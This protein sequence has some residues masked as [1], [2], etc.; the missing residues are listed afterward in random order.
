[1]APWKAPG[2]DDLPVGF[3]KACGK[4]LAKVL[5]ILAT[6]CFK[7]GLFPREL[8]HAK[9]TVLQ[10][11]GKKPAVYK[12]AGGYR[13]IA[14]LPCLGKIIEAIAAARIASAAEEHGLLPEEQMGNRKH[15]STD[16]AIRLLVTQMQEAFR[17]KASG[18]LLQLDIKGYFDHIIHDWLIYTL[19][20]I[21]LPAWIIALI[22]AWL[23]GRRSTLFFDGAYSEPI[24][25]RAGVPQG[26]PLSPILAILFLAPLYETLKDKHPHLSIL[27]FADDT[28]ILALGLSEASTCHQLEEAW[29]TCRHWAQSRGLTFAPEKSELIH[30]TRTRKPWQQGLQLGATRITPQ[31]D[32]RFLGVWLDRKLRWGAHL[33]E[34]RKRLG[35]QRLALT[36]LAA[37]TWGPGLVRSREL[38]TKVV[39]STMAYGASAYHQ[40]TPI[41][42][43]PRGLAI[44]L[45]KEQNNCLLVVTGAY[46][47][48][49]T[50]NLEMEALVPP[51]DLYLN[52]RLAEFEARL[53]QSGLQRPIDDA[54]LKVLRRFG[55]KGRQ[56]CRRM[57]LNTAHRTFKPTDLDLAQ[58][59]IGAWGA[60]G[61]TPDEAVT[62]EWKDRFLASQR[63]RSL[64]DIQGQALL[65][66]DEPKEVQKA[67]RKH[68]RRHKKLRKEESSLLVQARTGRIGLRKFL[69]LRRVPSIATPYC[70]CGG[71]EETVRHVVDGCIT[72]PEA[73]ELQRKEGPTELLIRR[74]QEGDRV[75]PIL[76]WLMGR[77]PEYRL[78]LEIAASQG[79][80]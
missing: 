39:R 9:V 20:T 10:K 79:T 33:R 70:E 6:K 52:K 8:K 47:A 72:N 41:G 77:L 5:A 54:R 48:T 31:E 34:L 50:R 62:R 69:F 60:L 32:G 78:A 64:A 7:L 17:H 73:Y 4:P 3:L 24:E 18:S 80:R 36:R 37:K 38:Y 46:K 53:A 49:P 75:Q 67:L 2:L 57:S 56:G 44:R 21:G 43:K 13:P 15:R 23:R 45:E 66:A 12:T 29:E 25:V 71:E 14:L 35:T 1:M 27:G 30:F 26:S 51:L 59:T 55:K 22:S 16:L 63:G 61:E 74:L 42:G 28:N 58:E 40:P 65:R 68:L 19:Q 11:P 76:R